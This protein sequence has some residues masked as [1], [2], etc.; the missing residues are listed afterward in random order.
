MKKPAPLK[1]EAR[2]S[3]MRWK[4]YII[5]AVAGAFLVLTI[6]TT[7]AWFCG[8]KQSSLEE[9]P[10]TGR[11]RHTV[12]WLG[13]VVR[14]RVEED[15]VSQWADQNSIGSIYPAQYGWTFVSG[16]RRSWFGPTAAGDGGS[17]VPQ[18]IYK[19]D[20]EMEGLTREQILQVYQEELVGY[21]QEHKSTR[22]IQENW[23]R[24]ASPR[25]AQVEH[26]PAVQE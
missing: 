7:L 3:A 23:R 6:L 25:T 12:V 13:T 2:L 22:A 16:E 15:D 21:W 19:G 11:H 18:L 8:P 10:L 4:P 26:M 17:G 24:K 20:I 5:G 9:D 14:E 1:S